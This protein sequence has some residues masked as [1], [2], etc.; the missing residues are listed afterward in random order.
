MGEEEGI[1]WEKHFLQNTCTAKHQSLGYNSSQ[2]MTVFPLCWERNWSYLEPGCHSTCAALT[3]AA[4]AERNC[5]LRNVCWHPQPCPRPRAQSPSGTG[6]QKCCTNCSLCWLLHRDRRDTPL[7]QCVSSPF[8]HSF[9]VPSVAV[10]RGENNEMRGRVG[11]I[12]GWWDCLEE[13]KDKHKNRKPISFPSNWK[14]QPVHK[15]EVIERK[16]E[17][18]AQISWF[19]CIYNHQPLSGPMTK[20][21]LFGRIPNDLTPDFFFSIFFPLLLQEGKWASIFCPTP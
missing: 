19:F 5:R 15:L 20:L 6:G 16:V 3:S 7:L 14:S 17:L 8:F 18:E 2:A 1:K 11:M 9:Q 21:Y 13:E 10:P 12:W 4:C